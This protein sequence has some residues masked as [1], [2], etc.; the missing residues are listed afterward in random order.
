MDI[1]IRRVHGSDLVSPKSPG[2]VEA[3]DVFIPAMKAFRTQ[4]NGLNAYLSMRKM[5]DAEMSSTNQHGPVRFQ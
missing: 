3:F 5:W 1:Y 4:L 2:L